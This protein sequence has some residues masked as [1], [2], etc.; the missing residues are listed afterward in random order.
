MILLGK[1]SFT[2][3]LTFQNSDITW[4]LLKVTVSMCVVIW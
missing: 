3:V 1:Q 2:A 4:S